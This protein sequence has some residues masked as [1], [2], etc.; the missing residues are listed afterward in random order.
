MVIL[1]SNYTNR[2]LVLDHLL[3]T[4]EFLSSL[5]ITVKSGS[6]KCAMTKVSAFY[7]S[8]SCDFVSATPKPTVAHVQLDH[9]NLKAVI[10]IYSMY[11]VLQN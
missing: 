6:V 2:T 7:P 4:T 5:G 11:S 10:S 1:E 9:V 3:S 8:A